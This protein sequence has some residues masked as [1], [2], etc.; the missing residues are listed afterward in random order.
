MKIDEIAKKANVSRSTV[1][2]VLNNNPNVK[3]KTRHAVEKVIYEMNYVP[4]AAARSLVTKRSGVIGVMVYNILQPFWGSIFAGIEQELTQDGYGLM[5][6]NSKS[7]MDISDFSHNYK[8]SLRYMLMQNIDGLIF[9]TIDDLDAEDIS[10]LEN[11]GKPFVVIQDGMRYNNISSVNI[12]NTKTAYQATQYLVESG[13]QEIVFA[14]GPT[15]KTISRDRLDGFLKSAKENGLLLRENSIISC[16][17]RFNDGYWCMKRILHQSPNATAV[18]F[19]N[20]ISAY[21]AYHAADEE[22]LDIPGDL[23]LMGIDRLATMTDM[24]TYIPDLSTMNHPTIELGVD[25]AKLLLQKINGEDAAEQIFLE[26]TLYKGS[27]VHRIAPGS[28]RRNEAV[29]G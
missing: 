7:H 25:A 2:R 5:L 20:D 15:G 13:H 16:G 28:K 6:S 27:T 10:L 3:A 4:N 8:K 22:G 19:S 23:S 14:T 26:C 24:A 17:F 1:S 18:L 11:A 29:G 12:D 21:G 9:A